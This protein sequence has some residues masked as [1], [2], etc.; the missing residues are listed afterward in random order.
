MFHRATPPRL[1][2][3]V[4]ADKTVVALRS[5]GMHAGRARVRRTGDVTQFAPVPGNGRTPAERAWSAARLAA[6]LLAL[7]LVLA[8][9]G[10]P[11][12][13]TT[14]A[15]LIVLAQLV[16]EQARSAVDGVF[17]LPAA[18]DAAV[19]LVAD[20]DRETF[21]RCLAT[22]HRIR[23]S[24]P[25]LPDMIDP[26]H[27]EVLLCRALWDLAGVLARRQQI[28]RVRAELYAIRVDGLP[29]D[30]PAVAALR[31]QRRDIEGLWR[32][33]DTAVRRHAELLA[34]AAAAG[35]ALIREQRV[36]RAARDAQ[37]IVAQLAAARAP[38]H[39]AGQ[40]LAER[41]AAVTAAYLELAAR[42]GD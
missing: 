20:A 35:D 41:T 42:Y 23:S 2:V 8:A 10:P 26:G 24:W 14:P 18:G 36:G 4:D 21:A 1:H 11:W 6:V 19:V 13:S 25:A 40:D 9:V 15:M 29:A 5:I 16:R 39:A 27:A 3:G 38:A 22:A 37:L 33:V 12:W 28:R 17:A 34:E 31:E 30:S 32:Q 7:G